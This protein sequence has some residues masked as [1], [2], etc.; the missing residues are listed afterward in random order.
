M[1]L[2][3]IAITAIATLISTTAF[4]GNLDV[5]CY[6]GFSVNATSAV[7][8]NFQIANNASNRLISDVNESR[9]ATDIETLPSFLVSQYKFQ[10]L[11]LLVEI[12]DGSPAGNQIAQLQAI[13]AGKRAGEK[14]RYMGAYKR[15]D[16]GREI[17]TAVTCIVKELQ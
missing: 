6:R 16:A 9:A 8:L 14:A 13:F 5:N 15:N 11:E 4:A 1:K 7:L 10:P 3:N 2:M 12:D 17:R